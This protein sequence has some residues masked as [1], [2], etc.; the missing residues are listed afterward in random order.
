MATE[1][2]ALRDEMTVKQAIE[3]LQEAKDVEMVFYVYVV[4]E[5]NHLVGVLSLRQL[6]TVP[7][8]TR[9]KEIMTTDVI[10]VRTDM[11][12]EEVAQLVV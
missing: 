7:P 10:R 3:A 8:A 9:L 4:D 2:F 12:Q 1:V 11:D 5:H 6:L